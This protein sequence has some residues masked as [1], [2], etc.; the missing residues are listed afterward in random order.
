[1]AFGSGPHFCLGAALARIELRAVLEALAARVATVEP[2]GA[3]ERSMSLVIAGV[4]RAP[5]VFGAA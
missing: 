1:V 5:L 4:R 3:V 2:A